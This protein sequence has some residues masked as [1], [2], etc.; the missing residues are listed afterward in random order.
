MDISPSVSIQET[1]ALGPIAEADAHAEATHVA[2]ALTGTA[3]AHFSAS[4]GYET[5][6]SVSQRG[7]LDCR[8]SRKDFNLGLTTMLCKGVTGKSTKDFS[9]RISVDASIPSLLEARARTMG[10]AS[11]AQHAV[12]IAVGIS[13]ALVVIAVML[14]SGWLVLSEWFVVVA[15]AGGG[16]A[17]KLVGSWVSERF[18]R[19]AHDDVR[20]QRAG[21]DL[22]EFLQDV[23]S[24]TDTT[25]G[26]QEP[27]GPTLKTG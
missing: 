6:V 1:I 3:A 13:I 8:V 26:S 16:F 19:K 25:A 22:D 5:R 27:R 12:T 21:A 11:I 2:E 9:V 10:A 4:D 15:I 24:L 14:I 17:G 20:V 23:A 7:E 18:A